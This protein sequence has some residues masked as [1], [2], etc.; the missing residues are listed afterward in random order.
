MVHEERGEFKL[1][2]ETES[3]ANLGIYTDEYL[4]CWQ[5]QTNFLLD[6]LATNNKPIVDLASG[7]GYLV[8]KLAQ[9][10]DFPIVA[11]DFSPNVLRRNRRRFD[12]LGIS[13]RVSLLAFDALKMPF[14]DASLE[15]I[16]TNLGLPNIKGSRDLLHEL[17]RVLAGRF[18]SITHFY[19]ADDYQNHAALKEFG[20]ETML[21]KEMAS[22][23]FAQ[24]GWQ[25]EITNSCLGRAEPTPVG[26]VLEGAGIDA[27]P[28]VETTL[29]WCLLEAE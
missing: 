7:R 15:I 19:P 14:K 13:D 11:T 24:S 18:L 22:A 17:R 16:T 20:L 3:V 4:S 10:R 2:E 9:G 29:E 27:F 28:A 21:I 26:Q 5:S 12:Y 1:A 6:R 25:F 8:E 23:A